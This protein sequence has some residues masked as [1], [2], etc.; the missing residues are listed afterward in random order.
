LVK[1][2]LNILH[3]TAVY[4]KKAFKT[5]RKTEGI[6]DHFFLVPSIKLKGELD[7][8]KNQY[9]QTYVRLSPYLLDSIENNYVKTIDLAFIAELPKDGAQLLYTKVS[10][11]LNEALSKGLKDAELTY[12]WLAETMGLTLHQD[13]WKAKKQLLP[14]FAALVAKNYINEPSWNKW[15]EG[16]IIVSPGTRFQLGEY[17]QLEMRKEKAAKRPQRKIA[18]Q[19]ISE[20]VQPEQETTDPVWR[21]CTMYAGAGWT[22]VQQVA[23][24][25]GFTEESLRKEASTRG[26]LPGA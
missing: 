2:H 24:A 7:E 13:R 14:A 10:Y 22:T 1:R 15:D 4:S 16:I 11:A 12:E 18:Q 5:S 25:K 9:D 21:L 17:L 20:M 26:L 8:N 19:S 6:S 3:Y 23:Q